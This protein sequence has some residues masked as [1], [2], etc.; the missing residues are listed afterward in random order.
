MQTGSNSS[1]SRGMGGQW[2][3]ELGWEG[4]KW[5]KVKREEEEEE[6]EGAGREAAIA[7]Y[8]SERERGRERERAVW[9]SIDS[10]RAM[11]G[12]SW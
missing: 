9:A 11:R 1:G 3:G 5:E 10:S 2:F 8:K 6:E 7:E 12:K 4:E